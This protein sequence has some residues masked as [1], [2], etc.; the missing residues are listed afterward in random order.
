MTN[1]VPEQSRPQ[2]TGSPYP[3]PN[4]PAPGYPPPG[5]GPP[6]GTPPPA[7]WPARTPALR[8]VRTRGVAIA[9]AILVALVMLAAIIR[10]LLAPTVAHDI[11]LLV[12]GQGS[13]SLALLDAFDGITLLT[14]VLLLAGGILTIVWLNLVRTNTVRLSPKVPHERSQVWVTLGWMVPVVALWFPFQ[15]VRDIRR[16]LNPDPE[17]R[18]FP[19]SAGRLVGYWWFCYLA[20]NSV[21]WLESVGT[22][23]SGPLRSSDAEVIRILDPLSALL[24]AVAG[25][26]WIVIV[27]SIEKDQAVRVAQEQAT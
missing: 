10:A 16:A 9:V 27:A 8:P 11:D 6:P 3:P 22:S 5:D 15:V 14:T 24:T 1:D 23:S 4:Y 19:S 20:M 26:L 7:P 2:Q 13:G 12:A 21:R 18:R 25:V 17:V